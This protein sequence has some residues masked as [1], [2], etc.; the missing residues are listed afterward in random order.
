MPKPREKNALAISVGM[1]ADLHERFKT[2]CAGR[3]E[4]I[5]DHIR[6]AME[7][8]L[9]YPP[10]PTSKQKLPAKGVDMPERPATAGG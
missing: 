8:H 3:Q 10:T 4:T 2:F 6:W 5:S 1:S 9:A 7:R